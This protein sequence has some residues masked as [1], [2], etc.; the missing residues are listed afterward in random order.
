MDQNESKSNDK[1]H[2]TSLMPCMP[3]SHPLHSPSPVL[4]IFLTW[5]EVIN[6]LLVKETEKPVPA[7]PSA[8][9]FGRSEE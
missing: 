5:P 3:K 2:L 7:S 4:T 8:M 6:Q 9:W 1:A